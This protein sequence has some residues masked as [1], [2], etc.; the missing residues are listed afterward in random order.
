MPDCVCSR[1]VVTEDQRDLSAEVAASSTRT[2]T[3][4]DFAALKASGT[5]LAAGEDVEALDF[6]TIDVGNRRHQREVLRFGVRTM[7]E[8]S[9]DRHVEL[10]REVRESL[11]RRNVSVNSRATGEASKSSCASGPQPHTRPRF[12]RCPSPSEAIEPDRFQLF[13][14]RAPSQS[15]TRGAGICCRVVMSANRVR[16]RD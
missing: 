16:T 15:E 8:A 7:L 12:G 11:L 3:F 6:L 10:S 13:E 2:K 1:S 9:R 4:R 14:S 5:H